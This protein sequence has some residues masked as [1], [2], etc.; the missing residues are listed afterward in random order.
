M[1]LAKICPYYNKE[2]KVRELMAENNCTY[3]KALT[4]YVQPSPQY[5]VRQEEYIHGNVF[6]RTHSDTGTT[7]AE[8]LKIT[9]EPYKTKDVI[10]DPKP[11]T[12]SKSTVKKA[13]KTV[14][15]NE[16]I[17][18]S[19][20][21][22]SVEFDSDIDLEMPVRDEYNGQEREKLYKFYVNQLLKTIKYIIFMRKINFLKNS[23]CVEGLFTTGLWIQL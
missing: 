15:E 2:R 14:K 3:K 18:Q 5:E 8:V 22:F 1:A 13:R 23:N 21:D 4:I 6:G 7:Y 9:S 12:I 20:E 17:A 10:I 11:V 19:D 16:G